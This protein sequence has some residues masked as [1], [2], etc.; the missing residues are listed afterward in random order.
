M[1]FQK[2][3]VA[4]IRQQ[5]QA[6]GHQTV[7]IALGVIGV[8][9]EDAYVVLFGKEPNWRQIEDREIFTGM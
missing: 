2:D 1:I 8:P 3:D 7:A 6:H 9:F 5:A 4:V